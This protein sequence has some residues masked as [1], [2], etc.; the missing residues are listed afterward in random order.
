MKSRLLANTNDAA[1]EPGASVSGGETELVTS[2]AEIIDVSVNDDRSPDDGKRTGERDSGVGDLYIGD[3]IGTGV[4]V[5]EITSVSN[6]VDWSSMRLSVGIEM[7]AGGGATVGVV[8]E[9]VDMKAVGAW[10]ETLEFAHDRDRGAGIGLGEVDRT[11]D[12]LT[13]QDANSLQRHFLYSY[14]WSKTI[15]FF[16]ICLVF[17]YF[18]ETIV[19]VV[20]V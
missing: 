19:S 1:S 3:A 11:L 2:F 7:S 8:A 4:D 10:G 13:S 15:V 6:I 14:V 18:R 20:K 5:T 17:V 12:D 9:F 16:Y